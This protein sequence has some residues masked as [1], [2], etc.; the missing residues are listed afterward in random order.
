MVLSNFDDQ[1]EI[2][3]H[4]ETKLKSAFWALYLMLKRLLGITDL[5]LVLNVLQSQHELHSTERVFLI[6]HP[7]LRNCVLFRCAQPNRKYF[8]VLSQKTQ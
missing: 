7:K 4:L 6:V 2:I 1:P 8:Y 3:T 5:F